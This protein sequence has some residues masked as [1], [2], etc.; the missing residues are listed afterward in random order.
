MY[1]QDQG[2]KPS[3]LIDFLLV[4]ALIGTMI[5]IGYAMN[6]LGGVLDRTLVNI[7]FV[8]IV[9]LACLLVYNRRLSAFRYT[10][11]YEEPEP[12][13]DPAYGGIVTPKL[14]CP[15]GTLIV[16]KGIADKGK[17]LETVYLD[18]M[19]E[20]I[21]PNGS[22]TISVG[23]GVKVKTLILTKGKAETAHTLVFTRDGAVYRLLFHPD[24][25][26]AGLLDALIKTRGS[27]G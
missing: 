7:L 1:Q 21:P 6:A 14:A 4:V 23:E 25:K 9:V 13:E 24:E 8:A 22:S 26:L 20:L 19:E 27:E 11:F 18:D 17:V 10:L 15:I 3:A 12:Y 16:Q 2:K 5:A